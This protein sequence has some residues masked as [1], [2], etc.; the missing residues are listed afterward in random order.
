MPYILGIRLNHH[1][2]D[3]SGEL[4]VLSG[5]IGGYWRPALDANVGSFVKG[6]DHRQCFFDPAQAH[7]VAVNVKGD[8]SSFSDSPSV[9]CE[10]HSYLMFA[11]GKWLR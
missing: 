4:V 3:S 9:V 1:E 5:H 10:L 6:A 8:G 11:A 7:G 2:L